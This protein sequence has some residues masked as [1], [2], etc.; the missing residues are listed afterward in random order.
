[1][2]ERKDRFPPSQTDEPYLDERQVRNVLKGKGEMEEE[3]ERREAERRK[4]ATRP[5]REVKTEEDPSAS[6]HDWSKRKTARPA[7]HDGDIQ[8]YTSEE[9]AEAALR[10][11]IDEDD[12]D[13]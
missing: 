2:N 10:E 4:R 11:E 5:D 1:M 12:V 13:H 3:E 8:G 7:D 9:Q 6:V